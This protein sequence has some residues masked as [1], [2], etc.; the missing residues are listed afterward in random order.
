MVLSTLQIL[1][2]AALVYSKKGGVCECETETE[3]KE[4]TINDRN[5]NSNDGP[6]KNEE[7]TA[8]V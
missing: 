4:N 8:V 3:T 2:F 1:E 6:A 5:S 7:N